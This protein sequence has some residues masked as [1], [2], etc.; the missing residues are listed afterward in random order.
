MITLISPNK[1]SPRKQKITR[2]TIHCVVGQL[3]ARRIAE[4]FQP[5]SRKASCNYAVG[6]D[7]VV[8]KIVDDSDRSWCSS[9]ADND[10]RAITIEVASDTKPPYHVNDNVL[11]VLIDLC[12]DICKRHNIR[13][14]YWF[15]DKRTSLNFKPNDDEGVFTVHRW[16]ANKSCPGDYLMSKHSYICEQVNRR[17]QSNDNDVS[18][19]SVAPAKYKNADYANRYVVTDSLNLRVGGGV[20][21]KIITTIPKNDVVRCFGYYNVN[22]ST[23]WLLVKYNDVVGYVSKNYLEVL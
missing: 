2:I 3:T 11:D 9:N 18:N 16:F 6:S 23:V 7:G 19:L 14:M 5:K 22:G 10:N 8:A 13:R 17:L 20:K 1:T 21:Y 15:N 4:L 12:V